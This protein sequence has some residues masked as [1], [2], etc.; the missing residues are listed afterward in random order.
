MSRRSKAAGA[1]AGM[2]GSAGALS[3]VP[4]VM[5]M[6]LPLLAAE[7]RTGD[8]RSAETTRAIAEKT[9]ALAE[10]AVAEQLALVQ[11]AWRFWPELLS[12][13]VPSLLDG[14]AVQRSA[15]EALRPATRRVRANCRRLSQ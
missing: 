1:A 6:R 15:E 14:S 10:G 3:L 2:L 11:A 9:A 4:L 7:A 5:M 12:G 13:R 8:G